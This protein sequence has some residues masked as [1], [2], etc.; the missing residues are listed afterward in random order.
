MSD[1]P[2]DTGKR[3]WL[4]ASGCA[5][6]FV[7]SWTDEWHVSYLSA[8]GNANGSV[9]M[10]NWDFGLT[11]RDRQ[12]KP[13][14]EAVRDAFDDTPFEAG[15][16]W[17]RVSVVVCTFNGARTLARCLEE[18]E[19]LDYPDFEVIVVD[20]GSTDD[21]AAIAGSHDCRLISTEN[22]GLASARNTGMRAAGGE[23]V[24]Y[25]DDD[26][27]P[28]PHWLRYLVATMEDGGFAGAGGPNLPP[29]EDGP[30]AVR[31]RLAVGRVVRDEQQV[32]VHREA[33][34][35]AVVRLGGH[36]LMEAVARVFRLR[37]R[38]RVEPRVRGATLARR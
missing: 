10:R 2:V 26:A 8:K 37:D 14:L 21:S 5:G 6:A 12:P 23:I 22:H 11:D 15:R 20:D 29:P 25:L 19:R 36:V 17:P 33:R 27:H 1:Q 35:V 24:A 38:E 13:A 4:I 34:E 31:V 30:V 3:T 16:R 28:D 9:E 7:F 18:L 32:A